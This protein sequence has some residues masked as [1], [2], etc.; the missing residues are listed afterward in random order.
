MTEAKTKQNMY[1]D[2]KHRWNVITGCEFDCIYCKKSFQLQ[3]KR[4]K[5]VIDKNGKK[6]GCQSCYDYTPH[7]HPER[8]NNSLPRTFRHEFI[9][10]CS[11]GDIAFAKE[12]WIHQVLERIAQL[13]DRTFFFQSKDPSCFKKYEFPSNVMLGITL[14]TNGIMFFEEDGSKK[15]MYEEICKAPIPRQRWQDFLNLDF[16]RK[17]VTIEP[18]LQ[19][20]V[21]VLVRWMRMLDPIRIYVGYD[22]KK[23]NLPEPSL[24]KTKQLIHE[25]R[26]FTIVKEKLLREKWS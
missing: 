4:Q 9:W 2:A 14:E 24:T 3:M 20:D 7:F 26:R 22:T 16:D 19:F 6:R 5:P 15:M 18:I 23:S 25:L 21:N 17:I 1:E 11:S 13:S 8:L 12:E 10:A